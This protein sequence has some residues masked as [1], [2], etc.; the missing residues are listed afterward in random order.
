LRF[1]LLTRRNKIWKTE[2]KIMADRRKGRAELQRAQKRAKE[3]DSG[4]RRSDFFKKTKKVHGH[5]YLCHIPGVRVTISVRHDAS[6]TIMD[7][8]HYNTK[9]RKKTSMH[10][11]ISSIPSGSSSQRGELR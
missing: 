7:P 6:F 11:K 10:K 3:T 4:F 1:D 2:L 8:Y 9:K 5:I